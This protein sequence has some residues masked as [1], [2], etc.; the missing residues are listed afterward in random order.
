MI[1]YTGKNTKF[2]ED[3]KDIAESSQTTMTLLKSL[4]NKGHYLT[5]DNFYPNLQLIDFLIDKN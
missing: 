4:L 1:I 3:Y 2:D 5:V